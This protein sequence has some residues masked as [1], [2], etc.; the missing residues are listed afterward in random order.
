M[1]S[2]LDKTVVAQCEC[3][4]DKKVL[5]FRQLKNKWP[6]CRYCNQPMKVKSDDAVPPVHP[7]D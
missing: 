4:R 2:K 6:M 1:K 7:T 3:L 5:T